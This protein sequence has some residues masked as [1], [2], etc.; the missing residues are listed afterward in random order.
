MVAF[1]GSMQI[2]NS[3]PMPY[4]GTTLYAAPI[5]G[6]LS[7][8]AM[9]IL[10]WFWLDSRARMAAKNNEGYGKDLAQEKD[11]IPSKK[12][13]PFYL[14]MFPI[15]MVLV[16][17]YCFSEIWIP[18]WDLSYLNADIYGKK[19]PQQVIGMWSVILSLLITVIA[20]ATLLGRYMKNLSSTFS[21]G[22]LGSLMPS[23]N[24]ASEVGYG[25]TIATLSGFALIKSHLLNTSDGNPL[26]SIS[27]AT[28]LLAGITGS[29]AGGLSIALS[30]L[31]EAYK[32]MAI[33]SNVSL[34]TM[35]RI[36]VIACSGLDSLPHNGAVITLLAVCGLTHRQS[37][38]DI[39]VT[40]VIIPVGVLIACLLVV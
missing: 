8:A 30:S 29:A 38:K 18:K 33:A 7:G 4:F 12:I 2:H 37:Y 6:I 39:F 15:I 17:V 35:H 5:L 20:S 23:L 16:L 10:S 34:E 14:A 36:A 26:I 40:T 24:T 32:T 22:T 31:G 11:I 9:M 21:E 1:P 13:P 19:T 27:L 28:N 25:A 3:M